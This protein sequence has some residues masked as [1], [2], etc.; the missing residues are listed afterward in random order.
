MNLTTAKA[1][2][3]KRDRPKRV[4]RGPGTGNGKTSGKGHKGQKSRSGYKQRLWFEGGQ[5]PLYRRLP[6]RGFNNKNFTTRYTIINVQDLE[7]FE[8]G[9]EI[10]LER[11]LAVG[12]TSIE[13]PR[14]KV[15]GKGSLGK[16]LTVKAH[17]FSGS[18][19]EKIE[20]AG[21]TIVI[22]EEKPERKLLDE[23]LAD[24][25]PSE[26]S[27]SESEPAESEPGEE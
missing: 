22:L 8:A 7:C 18:A 4:G 25:G 1:M 16:A 21:G 10:D 6:R 17:K 5:M 14:L 27:E 23:A 20:A 9:E 24:T 3:A 19:K 11:I 15:L 2:G 12:L 13:T 26:S